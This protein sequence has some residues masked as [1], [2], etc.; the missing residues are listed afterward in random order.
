M[1]SSGRR[2]QVRNRHG[3]QRHQ[4]GFAGAVVTDDPFRHGLAG[5]HD[6]GRHFLVQLAREQCRVQSSQRLAVALEQGPQA[7]LELCNPGRPLAPDFVL[8]AAVVDLDNGL[9]PGIRTGG[10]NPVGGQQV[11]AAFLQPR[12]EQ[13]ELL[14][15]V[16]VG[17]VQHEQNAA[18][19]RAESFQRPVF[20]IGQVALT[21]HQGDI[22]APADGASQLLTFGP[23]QFVDTRRIDQHHVTVPEGLPCLTALGPGFPV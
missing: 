20:E 11:R 17:L 18:P 8:P 5:G 6:P 7:L 19:G 4:H 2:Q 9:G 13:V 16:A 14:R 3:V 10:D 22:G 21:D 23:V 15:G 12:P 1:V